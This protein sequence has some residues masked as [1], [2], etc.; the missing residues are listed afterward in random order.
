MGSLHSYK[1]VG[2]FLRSLAGIR[3]P[4]RAVVAGKF[5]DEGEKAGLL[6]ESRL[7][8]RLASRVVFTGGVSDGELRALYH[9]ADL[10]VYPTMGDTL[11]LVVLEAMACGLPVVSTTVGGIP[12]AVPPEAGIL[13]PPGD[14]EAV[15]EAVNALLADP[16]RR[17]AMGRMARARVDE[18][19]RWSAAAE[20]A[21]SG[22]RSVL[23]SSRPPLTRA[24]PAGVRA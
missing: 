17:R 1:G 23:G 14:A 8:A 21:L 9:L 5:K 4:F 18:A 6:D 11:P 24:R 7:G 13:V 2:V 22:Y 12:F 20:R 10:F 16:G 15:G 3:G 19:F